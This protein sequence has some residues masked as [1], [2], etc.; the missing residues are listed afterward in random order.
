M[1]IIGLAGWSGAGKTTLLVKLIPALRARGLTVSTV[2][3]AHHGFDVDVPG[4]DSFRHREAG[5][6]EVLVS[7]RQ[8]WALMGEIRDAP[9]P[10]LADLLTRLSPVDMVLVEG[11]K[12]SAHPKIEIHRVANGRGYLFPEDPDIVAVITDASPDA[13]IAPSNL[14]VV[15]LDALDAIVDLVIREAPA[16]DRV[17]ERLARDRH[18]ATHG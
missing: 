3:H 13:S 9:E 4:K 11:F 17:L 8:R 18:G 12:T 16:M 5:A 7:S 6:S 14:P 1:K 10:T 2:K 15:H